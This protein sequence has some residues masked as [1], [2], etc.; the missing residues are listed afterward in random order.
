M[1]EQIDM[2]PTLLSRFDLMFM[3]SDEPDWEDDTDVVEH[4]V[5]IA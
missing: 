2:G 5:H 3:M 1:S 4:M